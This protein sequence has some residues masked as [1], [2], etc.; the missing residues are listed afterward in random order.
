MFFSF[1][2][3]LLPLPQ[4]LF[5]NFFVK[6][7]LIVVIILALATGSITAQNRFVTRGA[8]PGEFYLTDLWYGVYNPVYPAYYDTLKSAIYR[9]TENGK[10]LTIQYAA[11]YFS[12][13]ETTIT[14]PYILADATTGTLYS[15]CFYSKNDYPHT[16]LWVSFDY[17]KNWTFREE[18]I[19]QRNYYAA[20]VEGVTYRGDYGIVYRSIDYGHFFLF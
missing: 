1:Q 18:N 10:K 17:G 2:K 14:I 11:N 12:D 4:F 7:L 20:N 15:K 16:S 8:E 19:G 13:P 6:R 5:V 3:N 9:L